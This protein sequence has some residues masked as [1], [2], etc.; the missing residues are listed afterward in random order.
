MKVRSAMSEHLIWNAEDAVG[1]VNDIFDDVV[2]VLKGHARFADMSRDELDLLLADARTRAEQQL[3][4]VLDGMI[5]VDQAVRDIEH[6]L[7]VS[8]ASAAEE[9]AKDREDIDA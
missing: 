6:A 3:G 5:A 4:D 2:D 1:L 7:S 9:W 8:H